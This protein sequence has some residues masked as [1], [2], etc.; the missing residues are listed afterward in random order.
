MYFSA[1]K[2]KLHTPFVAAKENADGIQRRLGL[3]HAVVILGNMRR[4]SFSL[5]AHQRVSVP[6]IMIKTPVRNAQRS[7]CYTP[8]RA[9][10]PKI[11]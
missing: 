10:P 9:S 5:F 1:S 2:G 11:F 6:L 3:P 7:L 4:R 8:E